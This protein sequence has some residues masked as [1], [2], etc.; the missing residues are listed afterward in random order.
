MTAEPKVFDPEVE[1]L[2]REIAA[3]PN[4]SLLRVTRPQA[5][6]GLF[7]RTERVS[8]GM[9]G[10][11][12]A[13]RHL[14]Q[15]HRNEVA[16]LLREVCRWRMLNDPASKRDLAPYPGAGDT[17]GADVQ[18]LGHAV[19]RLEEDEEGE[20]DATSYSALQLIKQCVVGPSKG[21]HVS[22]LASASH[23]LEPHD[24]NRIYIG[25]DLTFRGKPHAALRV[26]RA[27]LS[28]CTD[29]SMRSSAWG[30]AAVPYEL[31][32]SP[33]TMMECFR[34]SA[35]SAENLLSAMEWLHG[36]IR[37]E[38]KGEAL[39][40]GEMMTDLCDRGPS[41]LDWYEGTL[42]ERRVAW[43]PTKSQAMFA[44]SLRSSLTPPSR[45]IADVFA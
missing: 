31:L 6:K 39:R 8:P 13:E 40:A 18:E 42:L 35:L 30:N 38:D 7:E 29:P 10:L 44:R 17:E 12:S 16:H 21:V 20:S 32:N 4:S 34:R 9:T 15:V 5:V 3:D 1:A 27:L 14:V 33:T 19:R 41:I 11:S 2:L 28:E 43:S 25:L 45:R 23:R 26:Y 22:S 36:A 37:C 24:A